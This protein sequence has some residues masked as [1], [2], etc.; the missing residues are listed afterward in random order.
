[1]FSSFTELD[2]S[3]KGRRRNVFE[4]GALLLC[5]VIV[6]GPFVLR[7]RFWKSDSSR[8]LNFHSSTLNFQLDPI[9]L[10]QDLYTTVLVGIL[11]DGFLQPDIL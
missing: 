6:E 2:F 11:K 8:S 3:E 1:M 9:A 10:N 5:G 4:R 7:N